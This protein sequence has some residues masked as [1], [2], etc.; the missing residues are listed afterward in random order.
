METP[1]ASILLTTTLHLVLSLPQHP[2]M[3][4]EVPIE[5]L[6]DNREEGRDP[7]SGQRLHSASSLPAALA[8][9]SAALT[10]ALPPP[11]PPPANFV[12]LG[13]C[14]PTPAHPVPYLSFSFASGSGAAEQARVRLAVV[15]EACARGAE[16]RTAPHACST[17]LA[18]LPPQPRSPSALAALPPLPPSSPA[19]A[20][21][22][23]LR[24]WGLVVL[25]PAAPGDTPA[26]GSVLEVAARLGTV[27][28]TNY[29]RLFNVRAEAQPTNLAFTPLP[30]DLHTDNPYRDPVP[31]YQ[32]LTCLQQASA[33]GETLFCDGWGVA[34]EL[35]AA[36]PAHA[37]LL[38]AS[39]LTFRYADAGAQLSARRCVLAGSGAR[40]VAYN[41][42][43]QVALA[44]GS[45]RT[46]SAVRA[47]YGALASFEGLCREERHMARVL[48][49]PGQTVVWDNQR[50]LHGRAAFEGPRHLQGCYLARDSVL[51]AAAVALDRG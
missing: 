17:A 35:A 23:R 26:E 48:L 37:A 41:A 19:A 5:W 4:V 32:A 30:L 11:A 18:P 16:E 46:A 22:A 7:A 10:H 13:V 2:S 42:R 43:S 21:H 49:A 6:W 44:L 1:E 40:E 12:T 15:E 3:E 34:A 28:E 51:S 9:H 8:L 31:G 20:A 33:G 38:L 50:L 27:T 36:H 47:L 24:Q 25:Q 29:G 45:G 14:A 39:P